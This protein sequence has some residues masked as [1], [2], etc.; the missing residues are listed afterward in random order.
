ALS[1][2]PPKSATPPIQPLTGTKKPKPT[3]KKT[4]AHHAV[5]WSLHLIVPFRSLVV[6]EILNFAFSAA[7]FTVW[8]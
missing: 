6:R 7:S 1:S 8:R 3:S 2:I 4:H 5:P